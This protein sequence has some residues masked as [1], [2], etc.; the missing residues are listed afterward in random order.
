MTTPKTQFP[1]PRLIKRLACLSY[2]AA[3]AL[4]LTHHGAAAAGSELARFESSRL[5]MG[6][7]YAIAAYGARADTLPGIV[8]EALDEVDRIDRLMSHYKPDSALS[9]LNRE[10]AEHAVRTDPE[11]FDVIAEAIQYSRDSD[12]AF[13]I[14]VGPLMKLWGFFEGDGRMPAHRD[15]RT[16]LRRIGYRH[17]LLNRPDHTIRFD[18]PGVELDLG[19]IGKGY[20]VDRVAGI[21]RRRDVAAALISAGGSTVYAIG[22][23]PGQ[24]VWKIDVQDPL[25][26]SR[27]AFTTGLHDRALSVAAGSEKFFEH[28]GRR[29]AHIM[30]PRTGRPV[31]HMVG[32]AVL[33]PTGTSGDALDDALFV[34]GVDASRAYLERHPEIEA[35]FFVP[36]PHGWTRVRVG[37]G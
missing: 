8:D 21:L 7:V 14:T 35:Y 33:A 20:A 12:G 3:I 22:A 24:S 34:N 1:R 18:V 5:S 10:A 28:R 32:V 6:C 30:D 16:V 17:V 4:C 2:A 19:G 11:L 37:G 15:V 9:R 25:I 29:Y 27:I 23:P 13:D 31:Q 26:P 36:A